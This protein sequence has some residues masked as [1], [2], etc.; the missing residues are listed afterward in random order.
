MSSADK[1]AIVYTVSRGKL[2]TIAARGTKIIIDSCEIVNYR[3]STGRTVLLTLAASDT[4]VKTY[5]AYVSALLVV[6]AFYDDTGGVSYHLYDSVR[7]GTSTHSASDTL[8]RINLG[9]TALVNADSLCGAD[10]HTVA[11]AKTSKGAS[12]VTREAHVCRAA[13]R[14]AVVIVLSL[15]LGAVAV[16]SN[17]SNHFNNV[18][19]LDTKHCRNLSCGSVTA[20]DTEVGLIRLAVA[21][22]LGIA[23]ASGVSASTAVCT[24]E[25]LTHRCDLF[26]FLYTEE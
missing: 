25:A 15:F 23:V 1:V 3:Y 24:G 18:L 9:N 20:G 21:K 4:S 22:R 19:R 8:D 7:T 12:A 2:G 11:V 5:L 16:T 17:V 10:A 6:R 26:I 14:G 13:G